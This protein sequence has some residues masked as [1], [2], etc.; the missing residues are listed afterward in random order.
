M[1]WGTRHLHAL[2]SSSGHLARNPLATAFTVVVMSLALAL[3]LALSTLVRNA[4]SATGDFA[5][6]IGL[7]VYFKAGVT[8][9]QARQL[10]QNAAARRG[11]ARVTL[12]SAAQALEELRA[13]SGLGA[14]LAGLTDNPLP[15]VLTIRPTSEA[16]APADLEALRAY[17]AAWPEVDAVQL[18]SDWVMRFS[19]ILQ[20][21]RR[22]GL[23]VIALLAA[24]VIAVVGN[25]IRL[26]I[27]NR[28][29]EIE[30]T[31][32]VGGSNA[33]VR[34]PFLYTG[35]LYGLTAA[36]LAW[37]IVALAD[38]VLT[39]PAANLAKA[40]GSHFVLS[41]PTPRELQVLLLG[42]TLLGWL[43]AWL[44]AARQ[45]ARIEPR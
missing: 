10:Q 27:L 4:R 2:L 35:A 11:V 29:A 26:E 38:A 5:D 33:F 32:L 21:L 40:Y 16:S 6:A 7:T 22:T 25:T 13:Q 31:K 44:A 17:L 24:G 14:A 41:G 3:P 30:V 19:A 12:V 43:G 15:N 34:R 37:G 28:R 18:D 20:L 9:Q 42:A 1:A 23:I 39:A 8:E 45:L 36:L